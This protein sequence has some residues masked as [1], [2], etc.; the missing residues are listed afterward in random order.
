MQRLDKVLCFTA[1]SNPVVSRLAF[2]G[3]EARLTKTGILLRA[4]R[5]RECLSPEA[6]AD[7]LGISKAELL[8]MERGRRFIGITVARRI[9]HLF[10]MSFRYFIE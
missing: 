1:N 3:I 9:E 4:L 8:A 5:A 2:A 6:F 7:K 10:G